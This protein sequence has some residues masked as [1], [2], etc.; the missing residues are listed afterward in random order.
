MRAALRLLALAVLLLSGC[1]LGPDFTPPKPDTPATWT[2]D[3]LAPVSPDKQP[4]SFSTAAAQAQWW[5][6]FDDPTLTS[7][8]AR[9]SSANLDLRQ[10]ALRIAEAREQRNVTASAMFPTLS[11]NAGYT[12]ER[13]SE[14]TAFT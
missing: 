5:A 1:T 14:K 8:I 13:I 12:R 2:K 6:S 11:G 10:A 9:A 7:L 3:G 4:S